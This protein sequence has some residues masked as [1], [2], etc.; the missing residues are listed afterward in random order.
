MWKKLEK[1][2]LIIGGIKD[3]NQFGIDI[4]F[5]IDKKISILLHGRN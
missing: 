4:R 3:F 2:K 5:I 1:R